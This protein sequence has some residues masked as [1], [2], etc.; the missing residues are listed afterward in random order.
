LKRCD[1][2]EREAIGK[3]CASEEEINEYLEKTNFSVL[4][5]KHRLNL[6]FD[7]DSLNLPVLSP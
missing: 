3:D 2:E 6:I 4:A 7:Y 5:K 1:I